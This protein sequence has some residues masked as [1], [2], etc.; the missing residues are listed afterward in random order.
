MK[1]VVLYLG[2]SGYHPNI[3]KTGIALTGNTLSIPNISNTS[4]DY[5]KYFVIDLGNNEQF[6]ITQWNV[7]GTT[8]LQ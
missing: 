7:T 2:G 6:E 1:W 4:L 8:A 5:I 3:N